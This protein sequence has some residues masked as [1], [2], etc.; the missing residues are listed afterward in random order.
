MHK[1]KWVDRRHS[2]LV[3]M[4][5]SVQRRAGI[6]LRSLSPSEQKKVNNSLNKLRLLAQTKSLPA[7]G[8]C[9]LKSL[10]LYSYPTGLKRRLRLILS[11]NDSEWVVEDIMDHDRY[12]RLR[13][14]SRP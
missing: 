3:T 1:V 14:E 6:I 9:K 7:E 13:L 5:L 12:N 11:K 8:L 10:N 4:D 2:D